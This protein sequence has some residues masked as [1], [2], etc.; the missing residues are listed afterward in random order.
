MLGSDDSLDVFGVVVVVVVVA[1]VMVVVVVVPLSTG[2]RQSPPPCRFIQGIVDLH[3]GRITVHSDGEGLGCRFS[4][5][6]AMTRDTAEAAA[7]AVAEKE[8][9][10]AREA[11]QAAPPLPGAGDSGTVADTGGGT[12]GN[13]GAGVGRD[14][15]VPKLQ[16]NDSASAAPHT[17]PTQGSDGPKGRSEAYDAGRRRGS[18]GIKEVMEQSALHGPA[19]GRSG[20]G[21]VSM[22]SAQGQ[23]SARNCSADGGAGGGGGLGLGIRLPPLLSGGGG[24]VKVH[25]DAETD[26]TQSEGGPIGGQTAANVEGGPGFE[27]STLAVSQEAEEKSQPKPHYHLLCVP[28]RPAFVFCIAHPFSLCTYYNCI[29]YPFLPRCRVVDDS[30]LSRRMLCRMMRQ[31]GHTCD[32][33]EVRPSEPFRDRS[34]LETG[35]PH[36][37]CHIAYPPALVASLFIIGRPRGCGKGAPPAQQRPPRGGPPCGC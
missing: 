34:Q 24:A 28:P 16:L 22:A 31:A 6:I 15:S 1:V 29:I 13:A 32:E 5:E 20:V 2:H 4:L 7:E 19:R 21:A 26:A 3:G 12:G 10:K 27:L 23:G 35:G 30:R 8:N 37:S 17:E 25:V 11:A 14:P 33:A 9:G 18:R 36:S